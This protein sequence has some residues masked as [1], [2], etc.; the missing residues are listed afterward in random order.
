MAMTSDFGLIG[1]EDVFDLT[2]HRHPEEN[3]A[4]FP[5][6]NQHQQKTP[7]EPGLLS[8]TVRF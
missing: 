3:R 8:R 4:L 7:D 5:N 1:G 2:L 6:R